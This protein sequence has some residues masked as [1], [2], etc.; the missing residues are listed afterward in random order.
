M[1]THTIGWAEKISLPS[2]NLHRIN[3]KID[4]GAQSS[5]L[6]AKN[7]EYTIQDNIKY[8]S[9]IFDDGEGKETQVNSLFLKNITVKSSTG[10]STVRPLIQAKIIIGPVEF[11][12]EF[13]LIDRKSMKYKIL[14][15]RNTLQNN[16]F[17]NP[18]RI[19][20]LS[21]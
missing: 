14:I 4:T 18:S 2:F 9:F 17:I 20:L 19:Y 15:G 1:I 5:A 13:S 6:N 8:V 10:Q 21:P 11:M 12:T 16:F 7:I 3:A